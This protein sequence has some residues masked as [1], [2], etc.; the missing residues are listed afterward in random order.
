MNIDQI[1]SGI[2]DIANRAYAGAEP[3]DRLAFEVRPDGSDPVVRRLMAEICEGLRTDNRAGL[4]ELRA[5]WSCLTGVRS[6]SPAR[7]TPVMGS[8]LD[9]EAGS[10]RL[11][12][13]RSL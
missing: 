5:R 13:V 8:S 7:A 11:S 4:A 2:T 3:A 12:K 6:P 1:L 9:G 10:L